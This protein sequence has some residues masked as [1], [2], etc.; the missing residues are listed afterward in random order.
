MRLANFELILYTFSPASC[1]I[2]SIYLKYID[3]FRHK[4]VVVLPGQVSV[5]RIF[6]CLL[7][8]VSTKKK[9]RLKD[10][11]GYTSQDAYFASCE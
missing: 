8:H 4:G 7:E 6:V 5:K 10:I 1:E 2:I 9:K 11:V 3:G